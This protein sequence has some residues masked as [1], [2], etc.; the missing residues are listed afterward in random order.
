MRTRSAADKLVDEYLERLSHELRQLP[1]SRRRQIL[2]EV[3]EHINEGRAALD[4]ESE[5]AIRALL[6]RVG[7]PRSIG[8]EAGFPGPY[9]GG[10]APRSDAWVPWLLLVGGFVFV[11][12]WLVGFV[13]LWSSS[14][15]R[16]RDKLIGT[17]LLPGGLAGSFL[18][19]AL[20]ASTTTCAGVSS[21]VAPSGT[22]SPPVVGPTT[23]HCVTSG[24]SLPLPL[25]IVVLVI[26][27]LAPIAT[28][29]H[30]E[31]A[32]RGAW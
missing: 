28:A 9:G 4:E 11:V 12:G 7:D 18:L 25:G 14:T 2:A 21:V 27:L 10:G 19:G 8:A 3:A 15:W 20:P 17:F 32:R 13:M 26:V 24:F 23:M 29:I 22:G 31:R 6:G 5:P 30:L 16:L 1:S